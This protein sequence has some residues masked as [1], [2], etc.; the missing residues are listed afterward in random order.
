M[1]LGPVYTPAALFLAAAFLCPNPVA[2]QNPVITYPAAGNI[3]PDQGTIEMW[4]RLEAEPDG[5]QKEARHYF[6]LFW[7]IVKGDRHPRVR[8]TYQTI[9]RPEHFHFWWASTGT[10][11]GS[12]QRNPYVT[13]VETAQAVTKADRSGYR[14]PRTPRLKKGEWHCFAVTWRN[15]TR[16]PTIAAYLDG[17]EAIVPRVVP[18]AWWADMDTTSLRLTNTP[19]HDNICVDELRIS[20]VARSPQELAAS[21]SDGPPT[22]D[23]HTLLLDHM[24]TVRPGSGKGERHT[25][26]E[27]ISGYHGEVGGRV[28]NT[29]Y[30]VVDG[31]F[32]KAIRL[33]ARPRK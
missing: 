17:R 22:R 16:Q 25:V 31:K 13:S 2:A 4:F 6:S 26:A 23:I 29:C 5:S 24:D 12:L 28:H 3:R 20:A 15:G 21:A 33:T 32:G 27:Q 10:I 18:G 9:W 1:S 8:I 30:E 7:I 14:Y 19:H 11:M